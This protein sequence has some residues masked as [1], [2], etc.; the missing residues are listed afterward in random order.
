MAKGGENIS[1][2]DFVEIK[3]KEHKFPGKVISIGKDGPLVSA[4]TKCKKKWLEVATK[5]GLFRLQLGRC[6]ENEKKK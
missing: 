6:R 5:K 3:Y 4:L 1:V 2:G